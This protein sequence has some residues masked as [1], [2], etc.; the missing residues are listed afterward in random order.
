[1]ALVPQ[2][3]VARLYQLSH[4]SSGFLYVALLARWL[5]IL[6]LAGSRFLPGGIHE[7]LCGLLIYSSVLEILWLVKFR[8]VVGGVMT[9]TFLKDVNF[10]YF[11]VVMH[12][13][14]DYEHAPV[15]KN[16]SY[17]SFIIG[18]AC[19]QAWSHWRSLFRRSV[20]GRRSRVEKVDTYLM[21]PLLYLSEMYLLLLN[22]QNPG[23]HSFPL[24]E[25]IN[26]AVLVIFLPV[27]LS[28][29][30]YQF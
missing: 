19:T 30:K 15:L 29:Y 13:Y 22:V 21:M 3:L 20:D 17:S 1:M 9:R 2:R 23:F 24:L 10:L 6:P 7:F 5:I 16:A 18:L 12:Y 27:A 14:D 28:V 25:K 8:G 4:I 26:K 11:V